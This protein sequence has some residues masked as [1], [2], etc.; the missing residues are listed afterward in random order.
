MIVLHHRFPGRISRRIKCQDITV[1]ERIIFHLRSTSQE[2]NLFQGFAPAKGVAGNVFDVFRNH[3]L[4]DPRFIKHTVAQGSQ[5]TWN[6]YGFQCGAQGKSLFP[7]GGQRIRQ[8]NAFQCGTVRKCIISKGFQAIRQRY[9]LQSGTFAKS[10]FL[11]NQDGSRNHNIF[12]C[13]AAG[14]RIEADSL[15][16]GGKGHG[17]QPSAGTEAALLQ[18]DYRIGKHQFLQRRAFTECIC[19]NNGKGIRYG[20]LCQSITAGKGKLTDPGNAVLNHYGTNFI[21][22][23]IPGAIKIVF[24]MFIML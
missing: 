20:Y 8:S 11:N 9:A 14:K 21:R 15:Q 12:Q 5:R 17:F 24:I 10:T 2:G 23:R 13:T 18:T 4:P 6:G 1:E 22:Q 16:R 19:A 3:D 7:Q